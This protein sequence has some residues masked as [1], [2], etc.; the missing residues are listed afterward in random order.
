MGS[1]DEAEPFH[2][3]VTACFLLKDTQTVDT[4]AGFAY[5]QRLD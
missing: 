2:R 4:W 3:I 1:G 5:A